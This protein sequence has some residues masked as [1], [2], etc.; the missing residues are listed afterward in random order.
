MTTF[1][2]DSHYNI[3]A[4]GSTKEAKSNPE[5]ERFRSAKELGRLA[6]KWPTSRLVEIWN[7]LP[8]Q[9][10]V[11]KFTSRQAA[12]TR[13]WKAIQSLVPDRGQQAPRVAQQKAR[14]GIRASHALERATTRRGSKTAQVVELLRRPSGVTL[15]DLMAATQWQAH[16]VRGFISGALRKKMGLTVESTK[17]ADGERSYSIKA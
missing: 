13:I 15:K 2:I 7:T 9:K 1:T 10:P 12:V 16:S 6:E 4:Y 17:G 8:G 11:N 14:P 5:A 3:T